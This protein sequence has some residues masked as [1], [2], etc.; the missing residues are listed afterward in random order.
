MARCGQCGGQCD[1][2]IDNGDGDVA[3][4]PPPDYGWYPITDG[5]NIGAVYRPSLPPS[6]FLL[7]SCPSDKRRRSIEEQLE[8]LV[9]LRDEGI[10]T[11]EE[12]LLEKQKILAK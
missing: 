10:L 9:L 11:E 5:I 8:Q 6:R 3:D 7:C 2:I 12:F 1:G 4:F